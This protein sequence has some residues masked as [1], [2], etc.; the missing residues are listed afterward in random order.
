MFTWVPYTIVRHSCPIFHLTDRWPVRR[1][2]Q[3]HGRSSRFVVSLVLRPRPSYVSVLVVFR[4]VYVCLCVLEG[5]GC[6]GA[7]GV[8]GTL[9]NPVGIVFYGIWITF[10]EKIQRQ[11]SRAS[12][13]N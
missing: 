2:C 4:Q 7:G 5:R 3:L 8:G 1:G 12:Q 13:P 9:F 10:T 6:L 11:P